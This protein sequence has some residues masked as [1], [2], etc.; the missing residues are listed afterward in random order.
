MIVTGN[1]AQKIVLVKSQLDYLFKIKDLGQLKFFLRLEVARL[2]KG[3]FLN[4]RKYTLE[5]LVVVGLLRC[6]PSI[7]PIDP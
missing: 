7:T 3:I 4:Q 2:S 5:L 1:D 6:K